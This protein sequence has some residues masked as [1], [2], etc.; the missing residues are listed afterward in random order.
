[1]RKTAVM[2]DDL[3]MEHDPGFNHVE[4]PDRLRIIYEQLD[5]PD[6]KK[7]FLFPS[8]TAASDKII[9][10]NHSP[11][12]LKRVAA[13]AGKTFGM[14]DPDTITS[15]RSYDAA[16][17][18]VG[19]LIEGV[20]LLV[21]KE[22]DNCFALVRPPGHHAE[23]D[24]G[25]GFCLFNNVA[26]AAYYALNHLQLDR[27]LI[28]DWDLHHGN[29]T[30]SSFYDTDKVL[31]FSSHQYPFYP[32]SG[33]LAEQGKGKG[34]G[35]TMNVP[36]GAG[37]GDLG[38]AQIFNDLVVPVA[39]QYKPDLILV[40]AGFDIYMHDPLGGMNVT[41]AGF[42]YMARV[43]LELADE[44]C[45]GRVLFTLEGGYD[46]AGQRDGILAVLTEMV[47]KSILKKETLEKLRGADMPF[48]A[49][50]Q[51]QKIAKRFWSL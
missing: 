50:E 35:F 11:E 42:A 12:H 27:V 24:R 26:V 36:L 51:A 33:S 13:T 40:S 29:G 9:G 31:Y 49:L 20:R 46:I 38:Y 18:A 30:Q 7:N 2:K 25:M 19:A 47:G 41:S 22:I 4:S 45:G 39:R 14:L 16:C 10:L 5:K 43:L 1:M 3:F 48:P 37:Q 44:L 32:G 23:K 15:P 8:F 17:L 28:V 21:D 6:I 34:E